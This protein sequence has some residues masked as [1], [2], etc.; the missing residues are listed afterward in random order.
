MPQKIEIIDES[1]WKKDGKEQ[2]IMKSV[3]KIW[4]IDDIAIG[5]LSL[6][7]LQLIYKSSLIFNSNLA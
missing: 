6:S 2:K 4:E 5:H 3:V 1:E 7:L